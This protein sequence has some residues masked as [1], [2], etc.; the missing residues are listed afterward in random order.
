[1]AYK[2]TSYFVDKNSNSFVPVSIGYSYD[3]FKDI[4]IKNVYGSS[5]NDF[6]ILSQLQVGRYNLKGYF[7]Y[8]PYLELYNTGNSYYDV[9]ICY[10][11]KTGNKVAVFKTME[12]GIQF[13]N[14]IIYNNQNR[15]QSTSHYINGLYWEDF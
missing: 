2:Y 9:N 6:V 3:D 5:I 4:P 11:D 15:V 1:M 14:T 8:D 7:R 10:D 13:T 12:D